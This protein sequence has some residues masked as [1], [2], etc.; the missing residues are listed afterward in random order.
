M[1][2]APIDESTSRA[3]ANHKRQDEEFCRILRLAIERRRESCPIG[4][5]TQ[6]GTENPRVN[7][8]RPDRY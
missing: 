8:Q 1:P 3:I 4:V 6:P 5:S 2:R 7:Y